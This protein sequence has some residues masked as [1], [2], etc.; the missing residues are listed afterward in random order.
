M[1]VLI[2]FISLLYILLIGS[3]ILGFDRVE[4]FQETYSEPIITF[5]V[6]IPFRN[7]AGNLPELLYSLKNLN[8]TENKYEIIFV[9]DNSD[10]ES[11]VIINNFNSKN[12]QNFL[13]IDNIRQTNS[14]KKDAIKTAITMAKF[15]WI[16]TTDAD[17]I[18]P[19]NWLKS[20]NSFIQSKH[21]DFIAG[22]VTYSNTQTFFEK[23]QLL[24]FLS[25]IGSSIGGFGIKNPFMCNGANLAYKKN[26][27]NEVKGFEDDK[28][29]ASGDDIFMLEKAVKYNRKKVRY[30]KSNDAVV[31]TNPLKSI[32]TLIN[33]RIRWAA[34]STQYKNPFSIFTALV[35]FSMN[36]LIICGLIFSL[37]GIISITNW[38][39]IVAIKLFVDF[40]LIYKTAKFF[41]Q[42]FLMT[43]FVFSSMIYPFFSVFIAIVSVFTGYKW[44]GKFY[45]K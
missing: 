13:L 33:Q 1:T 43:S 10:D 20:Y 29:I 22:P 36:A 7:E 30:L 18:V 25:L 41:N 9:N 28:N 6:V 21:P 16:V 32:K 45:K 2:I 12:K 24:D 8:Y 5:S 11:V 17:C 39:Y 42:E 27:F 23:F 37:I 26:L 40:I 31:T 35:V 34:K 19:I 4:L 15:D 14:P 3:F 44:K 38:I